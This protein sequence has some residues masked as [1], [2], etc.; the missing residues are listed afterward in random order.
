MTRMSP[1]LTEDWQGLA[2]DRGTHDV[3][4][5]IGRLVHRRLKGQARNKNPEILKW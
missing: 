4:H 3:K 5:V 1:F 2:L